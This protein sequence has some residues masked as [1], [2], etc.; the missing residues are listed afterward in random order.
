M[1]LT[2]EDS[3]K[4]TWYNGSSP[5]QIVHTNIPMNWRPAIGTYQQYQPPSTVSNVVTP[6]MD[7]C[8]LR[9]GY[10]QT[11]PDAWWAENY[12]KKQIDIAA[13]RTTIETVLSADSARKALCYGYPFQE[14]YLDQ[15]GVGGEFTPYS[16]SIIAGDG[17]KLD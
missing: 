5:L 16:G 10:Q 9:V 13:E 7:F 4:G 14:D 8:N 11:L 6:R 3:E 17:P 2:E 1:I 12:G 15:G